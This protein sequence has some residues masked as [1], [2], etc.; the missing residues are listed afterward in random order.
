MMLNH[1]TRSVLEVFSPRTL[2]WTYGHSRLHRIH[3]RLQ[4]GPRSCHLAKELVD[5]LWQKMV[6]L[7]VE[8]RLIVYYVWHTYSY[9][10]RNILH[11]CFLS[12]WTTPAK[13]N[14]MSC[15]NQKFQTFWCNSSKVCQHRPQKFDFKFVTRVDLLYSTGYCCC[16]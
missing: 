1:R 9:C 4:H 6:S 7:L 16:C 5:P 12:Y 3:R 10:K 14:G 2:P 13:T 15:G 8:L 11:G